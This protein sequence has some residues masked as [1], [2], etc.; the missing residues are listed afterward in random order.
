MQ[1]K[2]TTFSSLPERGGVL[3]GASAFSLCCA[4][5]E[6]IMRRELAVSGNMLNVVIAVLVIILLVFLILRFV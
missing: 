2:L 1:P 6:R 4:Q 3:I 5:A